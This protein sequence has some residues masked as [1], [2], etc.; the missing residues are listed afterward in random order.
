MTAENEMMAIKTLKAKNCKDFD[1]IP[2]RILTYCINEIIHILTKLFNLIYQQKLIPA[3][4]HVS[5]VEPLLK[6]GSPNMIENYQPISNLCST[7]IFFE[8][9]ILMNL[10]F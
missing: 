5:K 9:I 4:W 10:T 1:R 7:S 3:Q 8:K 2:V 6:K